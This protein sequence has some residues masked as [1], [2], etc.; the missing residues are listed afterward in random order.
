[1]DPIT[2]E[3]E[4][5]CNSLKEECQKIIICLTKLLRCTINRT[6]D[7]IDNYAIEICDEDHEKTV[8]EEKICDTIK[9]IINNVCDEL[10]AKAESGDLINDYGNNICDQIKTLIEN[11]PG[12]QNIA[13]IVLKQIRTPLESYLSDL[14]ATKFNTLNTKICNCFL[15][16]SE[17]GSEE[18]CDLLGLLDE[19]CDCSGLDEICDC[20]GLVDEIGNCF[21][22]D[23][24]LS[25][26][27]K[28]LEKLETHDICNKLIDAHQKK[29]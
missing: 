11:V 13:G 21:K 14:L 4:K 9:Y 15:P 3:V 8:C 12:C 6:K 27:L 24:D 16:E 19:I 5:V 10:K 22:G 26:L 23:C 28:A 17:K 20:S 7:C 25:C 29:S 1:M 18:G 2:T